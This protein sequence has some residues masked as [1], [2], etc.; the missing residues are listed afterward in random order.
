MAASGGD[1]SGLHPGG[2][3]TDDEH[4]PGR[5][6]GQD[7]CPHRNAP[8]RPA[9]GLRMQVISCPI[10]SRSRQ[11]WLH[12]MQRRIRGESPCNAFRTH[13]GSVIKARATHD[14]VRFAALQDL[15]RHLGRANPTV[16]DQRQVDYL[17][18]GSESLAGEA[19]RGR[20]SAD[21]R[22]AAPSERQGPRLCSR[23]GPRTRCH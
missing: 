8:S 17:V 11:P 13:C 6:G 12:P 18:R 10:H 15:L 9:A 3:T 23:P 5:V 20:Q 14:Q 2:P 1:L 16:G 7:G 21:C 22:N 19:H 4:P